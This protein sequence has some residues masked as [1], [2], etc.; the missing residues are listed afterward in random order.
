MIP[1]SS[2]LS[3][4]SCPL[5]TGGYGT[6]PLIPGGVLKHEL[7]CNDL[8]TGV[9]LENQLLNTVGVFLLVATIVQLVQL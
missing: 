3:L 5:G 8:K 7:S 4:N 6:E 9:C 1:S 2:G